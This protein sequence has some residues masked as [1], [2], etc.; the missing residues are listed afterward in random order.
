MDNDIRHKESGP[1]VRLQHRR[2][3]QAYTQESGQL[4]FSVKLAP[5][6]AQLNL[7]GVGLGV[8]MGTQGL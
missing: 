3:I 4:K 1:F 5:Y 8:F 7:E 6:K 2:V